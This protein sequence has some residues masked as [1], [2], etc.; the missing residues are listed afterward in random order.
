MSMTTG[1]RIYV[2]KLIPVPIFLVEVSDNDTTEKRG[3]SIALPWKWGFDQWSIL[4][5]IYVI[6]VLQMLLLALLERGQFTDITRVCPTLKVLKPQTL[7]AAMEEVVDHTQDF[8]G[9]T[10]LKPNR[11]GKR[12]PLSWT[13]HNVT[14]SG[15]T[16]IIESSRSYPSTPW[17]HVKEHLNHLSHEVLH[18]QARAMSS[19]AGRVS[20]SVSR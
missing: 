13:W 15:T 9:Q 10:A 11:S 6:P 19:G 3:L 8:V 20:G 4:K 1:F 14:I 17:C 18:Q 7:L 2:E 5:D 16:W 12:I